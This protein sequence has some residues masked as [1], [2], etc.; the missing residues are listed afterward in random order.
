MQ[1]QI[2]NN[3]KIIKLKKQKGR[4]NPGNKLLSASKYPQS[5]VLP[6]IHKI[7]SHLRSNDQ[8]SPQFAWMFQ[9]HFC[10]AKCPSNHIEF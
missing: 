3:C 2:K 10:A 4:I 9:L 1:I 8:Q 5:S 6:G 7:S